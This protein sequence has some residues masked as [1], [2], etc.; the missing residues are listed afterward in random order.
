MTNATNSDQ[1][2]TAASGPSADDRWTVR[3][4]VRRHKWAAAA[5][6]AVVLVVVALT[7]ITTLVS[8]SREPLSDSASCTQWD[9]GTPAQ[10]IA[11]SHLYINEYGR[12]PNTAGNAAA[13]ETTIDKACTEASYLGEA[14][15]VSVL[16][17]LRH[18]F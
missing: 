18:A 15:D 8:P 6:A 17:S 4:V 10:K 11:Y 2:D 12:V 5:T 1:T 3:A 7:L 9:A 14:D 13:I 16:A